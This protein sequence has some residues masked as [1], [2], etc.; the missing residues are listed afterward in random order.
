MKWTELL[1]ATAEMN[2]HSA[3]ATVRSTAQSEGEIA[4]FHGIVTIPHWGSEGSDNERLVIGIGS[5]ASVV[6]DHG[7][8]ETAEA[9]YGGLEIT[10]AGTRI[11]IQDQRLLP[12]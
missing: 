1:M 5:D 2:G 10:A 6:I 12:F 3:V 11:T 7:L 9:T 8:L 4:R